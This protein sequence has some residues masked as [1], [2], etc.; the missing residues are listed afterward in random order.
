GGN[1]QV[2]D[3]TVGTDTLMLED[4]LGVSDG[5]ETDG[6][7]TITF[8]DGGTLTVIGVSKAEITSATG[9]ELG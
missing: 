1:D 3:F 2:S 6:N 9:W 7:T 5:T 4:G 8:S